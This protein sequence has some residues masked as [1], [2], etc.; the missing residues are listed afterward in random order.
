MFDTAILVCPFLGLSPSIPCL[1]YDMLIR[2][3][4][5]KRQQFDICLQDSLPTIGTQCKPYAYDMPDT[6]LELKK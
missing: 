2:K 6:C 3:P 1:A 4:F 5:S